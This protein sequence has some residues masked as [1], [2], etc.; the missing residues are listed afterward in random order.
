M[1]RESDYDNGGLNPSEEYFK[2]K[3]KDNDENTYF[4]SKELETP[5]Y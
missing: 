3:K 4:P 2:K 5:H 1:G